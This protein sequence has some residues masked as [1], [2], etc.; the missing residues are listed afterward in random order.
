[1]SL[2]TSVKRDIRAVLERD[3]AASNAVGVVFT[4]PGFQ[5]R[6]FHRVAHILYLKHIRGLPMMLAYATRFLTGIEI[7][8]GAKIGEGLFIDHGMGVVVGETAEIGDNVTLHQGVTLGGTS[9]QRI[10]RH[11]TLKDNVMIGVGAQLI[12]NI[13]IG[14]NSKVGAGSVVLDSVPPNATV[15][16]V[17]GRVVAV[18][19][20]DTDTVERLPDPIGE[21]LEHLEMRIAELEKRLDKAEGGKGEGI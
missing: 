5:A 10:K 3:P 4:Y 14:E 16:G 19:N 20:P 6:Q 13:T 1:M 8:P 7:H 9:T 2:I 17:P 18:R 21:H 15:V 11:P 12:G